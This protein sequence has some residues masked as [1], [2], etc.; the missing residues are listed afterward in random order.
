MKYTFLLTLKNIS[1]HL[2]DSLSFSSHVKP[3]QLY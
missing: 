3:L 2:Q 1:S